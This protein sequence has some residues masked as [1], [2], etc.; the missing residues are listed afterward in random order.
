MKISEEQKQEWRK[1]AKAEAEQEEKKH[2]KW[3]EEQ[4]FLSKDNREYLVNELIELQQEE[5]R[6]W[7]YIHRDGDKKIRDWKHHKDRMYFKID[8]LNLKIEKIKEVLIN[9]KFK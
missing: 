5:T 4:N 6:E 3:L 7:S 9:N 1:K 2:L 8:M